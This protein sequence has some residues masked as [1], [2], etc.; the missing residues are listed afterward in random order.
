MDLSK[1]WKNLQVL[2]LCDTTIPNLKICN[3]IL[4]CPELKAIYL[5]GSPNIDDSVIESMFISLENLRILAIS[6]CE[7]ITDN[8]LVKLLKKCGTSIHTLKLCQSSITDE[9]LLAIANYCTCIQSLNLSYCKHPFL[10]SSY[11]SIF[12]NC[13]A[14]QN[15]EA[16]LCKTFSNEDF[17]SLLMYCEVLSVVN[18]SGC[19]MLTSDILP[20][21]W[22][23]GRNLTEVDLSYLTLEVSEIDVVKK[24]L[25]DLKIKGFEKYNK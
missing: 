3:V 9:T 11:I 25:P 10:S 14:L 22:M 7:M 24:L 15:F 5:N 12:T 18:V 23:H 2:N 13:L 6:G 8:S 20:S 4:G 1:P 16:S 19:D 21:L 17:T